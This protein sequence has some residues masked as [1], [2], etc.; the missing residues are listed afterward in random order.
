MSERKKKKNTTLEKILIVFVF[1]KI[2]QEGKGG[3]R[4]KESKPGIC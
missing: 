3:S 2:L 4:Q 1:K